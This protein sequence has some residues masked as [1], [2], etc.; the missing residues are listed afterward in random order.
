MAYKKQLHDKDG[1]VIYPDVGIN[2]EDVVYSDDPTEPIE[3]PTPWI[4]NDEITDNTIESSKINHQQT[5]T[6]FLV[7]EYVQSAPSNSD[8][9]KDVPVDLITYRGYIIEVNFEPSNTSQTWVA[10][11]ALNSSKTSIQCL[12]RGYEFGPNYQTISREYS[13][14]VAS[15]A[16]TASSSKFKIQISRSDTIN[17]PC[18]Y[19]QGF[20][21]GDI[22]CQQIFGR[23]LK[24]PGVL[25]YIRCVLK[26]PQRNS[27]VR[28][29]AYY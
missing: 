18:F 15:G 4:T 11:S 19:A 24:G 5:K 27:C 13:E 7:Y 29:Y 16:A 26:T 6:P 17:F 12:Q 3:N 1:N 2:L 22:Y 14:M 10:C 23:V 28:A 8:V 25:K 9:T 20:G 21:G